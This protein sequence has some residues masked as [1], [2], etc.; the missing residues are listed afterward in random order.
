MRGFI[1]ETLENFIKDSVN[2]RDY[3]LKKGGNAMKK[4]E[5]PMLKEI[6]FPAALRIEAK[7][8]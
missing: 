7:P 8:Y 1:Q 2:S 3:Y 4:Y 5:A 6:L